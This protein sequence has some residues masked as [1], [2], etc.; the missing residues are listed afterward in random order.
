[1]FP[2]SFS[3]SMFAIGGAL[4]TAFLLW[5]LYWKDKVLFDPETQDLIRA[6]K[7]PPGFLKLG[8]LPEAVSKPSGLIESGSLRECFSGCSRGW[9]TLACREVLPR[10]QEPYQ[11]MTYAWRQLRG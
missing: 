8:G 11:G 2:R 1:M 3:A 5:I 10:A 6:G 7:R 9:I 4:F